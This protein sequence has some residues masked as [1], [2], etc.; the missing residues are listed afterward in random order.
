MSWNDRSLPME[1]RNLNNPARRLYPAGRWRGCWEYGYE[2]DE[3]ATKNLKAAVDN[4]PTHRCGMMR[5][6]REAE[7]LDFDRYPRYQQRQDEEIA[8][9]EAAGCPEEIREQED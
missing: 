6:R 9:W 4:M 7:V 1:R 8:A 5:G 2:V 3:Q